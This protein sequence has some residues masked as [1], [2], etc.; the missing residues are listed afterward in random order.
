MS[1][2][3]RS[4]EERRK[5]LQDSNPAKKKK[6][7]TNW[8][9]M[10]I[11]AI[12]IFGALSVLGVVVIAATSPKLDPKKLET[13]V[14]SKIYDMNDEE[15]SLFSGSEKRIKV[16]I[17]EVPPEV[18][19]AFIAT[20]DLRF[21]K[22]FGV[23][24][25]RLFGATLA[26]VKEGF[27][28][29]GASTITQQVVKNTLL[30]DEKSLTRKIREAYL[31]IQLEQKYSKDQILEMYLNKIYFG[32]NA[33]GVATAAKVYFDKNLE[34]L[35][36]HEAALLA[37]LPKAPSAYNP[38]EFPEKAEHRRNVVIG[39]MEQHGLISKEEADKAKK[40]PVKESLNEGN[41]KEASKYDAYLAQ[42]AKELE[43][44]EGMEDVN[45]FTDGLKIY[46][47]LDPKAQEATE[48]VLKAKLEGENKLL[49]SGVTLVDT[50]TGA[51]RAVGS[52]R[53][54][55]MSSFFASGIERQ[56]GSTIKP[57]LDYGPAIENFKWNTG[58]ILK[59]TPVKV[60]GATINNY[61][62]QNVGDISMRQALVESKNTTAVRA[63]MEVGEEK[64]VDFANKLGIG[65][66]KAYPSY[67]IGGFE[68]GTSP[69]KLAG[70]Y[71]AF[72]NEG[73]YNKPTTIR[74]IV[75]PDGDEMKRE[76]DP[77]P[78]M[79]DYT[80][81]MITDM[82][83][84]VMT[85]GTGTKAN[86]PSLN[87]AGKTGTTNFDRD[88]INE[89]GMPSDATK[90]AWMAGYT[91][92]YTAAVWTGYEKV[93]DDETN[94]PL[95]LDG[96]TQNF[97]KDIFRD[98]MSQLNHKGTD[99][100]KPTSV[101]EVALEKGTGKRASEFTPDDQ[102]RVELFVKGAD[103]PEVSDEYEKPSG[104]EG[105][106]AKYEEKKNEIKVKWDYKG[107][108][109]IVFKVSASLDGAPMQELATLKEK[110]FS[111]PNAVPG[112]TYTFQ[113][114][115]VD[116]ESGQ[117]SEPASTSITIPG[118]PEPE[119][120]EQPEQPGTPPPGQEPGTPPPGQEP[121]TPPPGEEPGTPPP[122]QEP[123]MPPPG[124]EPG[125]GEQG[126]GEGQDGGQQSPV[127]GFPFSQ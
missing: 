40:I 77:K 12:L 35:E 44:M 63:F 76:S 62:D 78:A 47:N 57:V 22:H 37:G 93:K 27:G 28:A 30:T 33:Y 26:N 89:T 3:Y 1:K 123:G 6:K 53:G 112:G 43:K 122:G 74:K 83:K 105:L 21:R 88:T 102:K 101:I 90:D 49:Q 99:F 20:E 81:Y 94:E 73:V 13:P 107:K 87:L 4:R 14:S 96:R 114:I 18:Q 127:P 38:F 48:N 2:D 59:D 5:A 25:R 16:K 109:D 34:D 113:V 46:T 92:S 50:Q 24:I 31:A 60:N 64:A 51:I 17:S 95:Y 115:A 67:A 66:D 91:T 119:E 68:G 9:K 125:E 120:P 54:V 110:K 75:F 61:N 103:L 10:I 121:G 41:V 98:I 8:K 45:V 69:L 82:L 32:S 71:A 58:Y 79:K 106:E 111:V 39:L 97:S 80:A 55:K 23:D 86:I 116:E 100:K 56:P 84:D 118:A 85:R 36:V 124:T 72:G 108:K 117:A 126:G 11:S 7:N 19:N 42:V 65:L 104:I 29:E 52:G 70:A 15:V